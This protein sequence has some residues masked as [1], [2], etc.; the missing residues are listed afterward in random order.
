[1]NFGLPPVSVTMYQDS[2]VDSRSNAG[3]KTV[4]SLKT[5]RHP[6]LTGGLLAE[7]LKDRCLIY[8]KND[9]IFKISMVD[10]IQEMGRFIFSQF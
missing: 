8:T 3:R 1:M 5:R 6:R 7:H 2:T 4:A 9:Y 10:V